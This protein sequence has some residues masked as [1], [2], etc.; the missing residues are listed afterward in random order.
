MRKVHFDN[1]I[2]GELSSVNGDLHRYEG[3]QGDNLTVI[4]SSDD[5]DTFLELSLNGKIIE[6]SDDYSLPSGIVEPEAKY[7]SLIHVTLPATG[8]YI[9]RATSYDENEDVVGLG[10][11]IRFIAHRPTTRHIEFEETANGQIVPDLLS[12]DLWT[13]RANEGDLVMIRGKNLTTPSA[14]L[15]VRFSGNGCLLASN[16]EP[17]FF[18]GLIMLGRSKGEYQ[19]S[20]AGRHKEYYRFIPWW[21]EDRD[22]YDVTLRQVGYDA[23]ALQEGA[24]RRRF[25]YELPG[26][27]SDSVLAIYDI[28]SYKVSAHESVNFE[29]S[30]P[31]IVG[32][33]YDL[34]I[35][36]DIGKRMEPQHTGPLSDGT[37]RFR[38]QTAGTYTAVI[39]AEFPDGKNVADLDR[40]YTITLTRES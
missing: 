2:Y 10:Y 19:F 3:A 29:L 39:I 28:F 22:K 12:H 16:T 24:N 4:L 9:C 33:R 23:P 25:R 1:K 18:Y 30:G 38:A 7:Y 27:Q 14:F 34:Y 26:Q 13:F 36:N 35:T 11:L 20:V 31:G 8:E 17:S 32:K 37:G 5:F 15:M 40:K 6:T 21:D